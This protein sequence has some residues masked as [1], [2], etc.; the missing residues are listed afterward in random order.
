MSSAQFP[1]CLMGAYHGWATGGLIANRGRGPR[2]P[3][4]GS[5]I[6]LVSISRSEKVPA[7]SFSSTILSTARRSSSGRNRL[8]SGFETV[9]GKLLVLA[10]RASFGVALF[11]D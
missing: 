9:A 8:C 2:P 1:R 3:G 10:R 4:G 6:A 11:S 5:A 7:F